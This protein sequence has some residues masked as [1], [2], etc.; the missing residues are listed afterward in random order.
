MIQTIISPELH[1]QAFL[2]DD[3]QGMMFET[4]DGEWQLVSFET[5][6]EIE[7]IQ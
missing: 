7:T 5:P 2:H 1:V 4:D 3:C 6:F